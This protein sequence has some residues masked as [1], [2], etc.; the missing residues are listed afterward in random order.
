MFSDFGFHVSGVPQIVPKK[1]NTLFDS[2]LNGTTNQDFAWF[3][4][5][6]RPADKFKFR[7]APLRNIALSPFF[8]HDGA[9]D[10]LEDAI[11]FHLDANKYAPLYSPKGRLPEDLTG[12]LGP[13]APILQ[14]LNNPVNDPGTAATTPGPVTVTGTPGAANPLATPVVLTDAQFRQLVDFV[15][16]GLLDPRATPDQLGQLIPRT[17]P[18]GMTP[19]VFE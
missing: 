13:L 14:L 3:D 12:P 19:L 15:R 2:D 10:R 8:F 16:N 11:A 1:T 5:T 6:T 17:L 7:T 9:F 4:F 18:S